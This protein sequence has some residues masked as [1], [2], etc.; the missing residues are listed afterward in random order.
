MQLVLCLC[1]LLYVLASLSTPCIF[2]C[3]SDTEDDGK[4]LCTCENLKGTC[5][6]GTCRGDICFFTWVRSVEEKG[7]FSAAN[8]RE[9]CYTSFKGFF[10]H[11]CK[12]N[13][14]NALITPPPDISQYPQQLFY[15]IWTSHPWNLKNHFDTG[16][17]DLNPVR[18][19]PQFSTDGIQSSPVDSNWLPPV[20]S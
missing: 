4:L 15:S 13:H 20:V 12:E 17:H 14:C 2:L 8:Y 5:V 6:N 10:V 1:V 11:C 7:C 9:Q 19:T 3:A 16:P 18:L